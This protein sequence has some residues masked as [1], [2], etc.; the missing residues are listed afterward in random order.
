MS[1]D[2]DADG[3]HDHNHDIENIFI[4]PKVHF[5]P[6]AVSSQ[7]QPPS[8]ATTDLLFVF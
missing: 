3:N 5:C 2:K 4:T 6:F 7:Q 8:P 1:F